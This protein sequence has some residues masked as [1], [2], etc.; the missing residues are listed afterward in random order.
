M[1]SYVIIAN[2]LRR[3][4]E[5][6]REREKQCEDDPDYYWDPDYRKR[7][8]ILQLRELKLLRITLND[9]KLVMSDITGFDMTG[10]EYAFSES[11]TNP[12]LKRHIKSLKREHLKSK[13]KKYGLCVIS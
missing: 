5:F 9:G 7:H 1:A 12:E 4:R 8:T 6:E 3:R 11:V 10:K 13:R 2:G